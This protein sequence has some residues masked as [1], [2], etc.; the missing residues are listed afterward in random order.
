VICSWDQRQSG[1]ISSIQKSAKQVGFLSWTLEVN[2]HEYKHS[3]ATDRFCEK[4]L[5]GDQAGSERVRSTT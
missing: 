4:P 2:T 1:W 3:N 5:L